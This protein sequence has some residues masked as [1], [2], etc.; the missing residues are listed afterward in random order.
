MSSENSNSVRFDEIMLL[1]NKLECD[2]RV[3]SMKADKIEQARR[4]L[5]ALARVRDD[6]TISMDSIKKAILLN[7]N[8]MNQVSEM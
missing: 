3:S 4:N 7:L 2:R 8:I 6:G 5:E 1:Q